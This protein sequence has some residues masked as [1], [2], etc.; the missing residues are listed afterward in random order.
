MLQAVEG[1]YRNGT[2]ELL[3]LPSQIQESRVLVTF[4]AVPIVQAPM[5]IWFGMFGG[6]GQSTEADFAI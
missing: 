1:I 6:V 3:E 2:I 4:L 5:F